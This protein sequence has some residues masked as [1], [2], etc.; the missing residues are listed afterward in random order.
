[1]QAGQRPFR[2]LHIGPEQPHGA[3]YGEWALQVDDRPDSLVNQLV[4]YL[5]LGWKHAVASLAILSQSLW[6]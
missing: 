1:M 2:C 6:L 3:G 4:Q 5:A